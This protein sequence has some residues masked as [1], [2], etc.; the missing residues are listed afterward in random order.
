MLTF[1][2]FKNLIS[3]IFKI[4]QAF[5]LR[6]RLKRCSNWEH[7]E[8]A[9]YRNLAAKIDNQ[10]FNPVWRFRRHRKAE[11]I[12]N[13]G[14]KRRSCKVAVRPSPPSPPTLNISISSSA[15]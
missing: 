3:L 4:M 2:H 15:S 5:R 1:L 12:Q 8:T 14:V 10:F 9:I 13:G 11:K 6:K 7:L